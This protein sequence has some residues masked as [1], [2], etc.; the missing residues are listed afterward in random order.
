MIWD[1]IATLI[2]GYRERG[3]TG[4]KGLQGARGYREQGVAG[5]K[6]LQNVLM[7][8]AQTSPNYINGRLHRVGDR[9]MV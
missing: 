8:C 7:F 5:S 6:G 2:T 3:V 9:R 1:K 4:S